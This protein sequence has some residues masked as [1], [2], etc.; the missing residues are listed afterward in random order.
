MRAEY[1]SVTPF[2]LL[3]HVSGMPYQPKTSERDTDARGE[4]LA[5]KRY[6]Y[7]KA[8]LADEPEAAPGKKFIYGGGSIIVASYL[9]RA[10]KQ[11]FEELLAKHVFAKLKMSSA[12]FGST[13]TAP[14]EVDGPGSFA[15]CERGVSR[16]PFT[17]HPAEVKAGNPRCGRLGWRR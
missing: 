6:E 3:G 4:T 15:A 12:A 1:R 8:A 5:D 16:Y 10:T 13:A 2:Q 14:D 9:E 7:V 17:P 11:P